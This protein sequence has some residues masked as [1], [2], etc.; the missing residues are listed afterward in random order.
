MQE[1]GVRPDDP[2]YLKAQNLL[3]A[4]RN[5]AQYRQAQ[6][7]HQAQQRQIQQQNATNGQVSTNGVSGM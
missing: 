6:Q 4:V 2:D 3:Q 5:E 1:Q 7:Q